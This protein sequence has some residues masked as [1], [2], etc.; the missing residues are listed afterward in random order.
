MKTHICTLQTGPQKCW[1]RLL[2]VLLLSAIGFGCMSE[3]DNPSRER[4]P[5]AM[6][7]L[8]PG[9][10]TAQI[11]VSFI[12]GGEEATCES[13]GYDIGFT[14]DSNGCGTHVYYFYEN[15]GTFRHDLEYDDTKDCIFSVTAS[16]DNGRS[17]SWGIPFLYTSMG[18]EIPV[19]VA[20]V[21]V[22]GGT[23]AV[24]YK[25]EPDIQGDAYLL[26]PFNPGGQRFEIRQFS[27]CLNL[28][29]DASETVQQQSSEPTTGVLPI[30]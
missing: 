25:Y 23:D 18:E 27:F 30:R 20:A 2:V 15:G 8:I 19:D 13:Q 7:K 12:E 21:I 28:K 6:L 26:P 4:S 5:E 3:S 17:L 1:G 10:A 14:V 24:L 16:S 11:S 22:K 29:M 9:S